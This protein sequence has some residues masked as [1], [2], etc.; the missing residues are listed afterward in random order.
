MSR[1]LLLFGGRSAEHEVSCVSA[2][3]IYDAL[4]DAGHQVIPIGIDRGGGWWVADTAH[5]P[6]RA[7][8]RP[9]AL[10]IPDGRLLL[11]DTDVGYDVVFPVLHGP[12][13][14][15]GTMQ[16]VFE[17]AG[18]PYVGC[19]VLPSAVAMDKDIAKRIFARAGI[20]TS[21]WRVVRGADYRADPHSTVDSILRDLGSPVF[22]KPAEL[23]SSV[24]IS[25][26]ADPLETKDAIDEALRYGDKVVVEEHITGR[27]IEVAVLEG[28]RTALPGEVQSAGDWYDYASKY[29]DEASDF[30]APANLSDSRIAEVRELAAKAFEAIECRG[31]ARVDFFFEDGG[32]GFL[33]NEVNTM[34]GFTPISGFPK[35]W[36]A[37]GMSYAELCNE[38]VELALAD[39]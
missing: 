5:R 35:M 7:E 28:P 19:G 33:I 2:V 1:V 39:E 36:M 27:E 14:E 23:G 6:F 31:L 11:G 37:T 34:P 9:A 3:A 15:D 22:V 10:R 29:E 17:I 21:R 16:G 20:P 38:L 13:G 4:V 30:E 24:G 32:R 18:K 8:G 12:H 25:K 26:A